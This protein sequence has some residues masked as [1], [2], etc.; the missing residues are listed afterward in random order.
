MGQATQIITLG[1]TDILGNLTAALTSL[2]TLPANPSGA[3]TGHGHPAHRA[4]SPTSPALL[5][6]LEQPFHAVADLPHREVPSPWCRPLAPLTGGPSTAGPAHTASVSAAALTKNTTPSSA[7]TALA[8]ILGSVAAAVQT[9]STW[10]PGLP[11]LPSL[12]LPSASGSPASVP[13]LPVTTAAGALPALPVISLPSVPGVVTSSGG[14]TCVAAPA[15]PA[16]PI[17]IN[18]TIHLG[19]I[20]VGVNTAGGSSAATVCATP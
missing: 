7:A 3:I 15:L 8:P 5:A 10:G 13:S 11:N 4:S 18:T 6:D 14:T 16:L 20:S 19:P 2:T 12:P 17:K 9:N 1:L